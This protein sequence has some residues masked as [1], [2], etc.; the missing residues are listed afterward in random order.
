M[1][2]SNWNLRNYVGK[3]LCSKYSALSRKSALGTE[4]ALCS[5]SR[6]VIPGFW[7]GII[8]NLY[9]SI[10]SLSFIEDRTTGEGNYYGVGVPGL[11][12]ESFS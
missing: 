1:L 7:R 3:L 12:E 4:S 11:S 10:N 6:E 2:A 8:R 5:C 9:K